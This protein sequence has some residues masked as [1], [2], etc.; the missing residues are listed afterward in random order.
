MN[1]PPHKLPVENISLQQLQALINQAT[2]MVADGNGPK[3]LETPQHTI[4]KLFR[5]KRR[6]SSALF[7]PYALR[8]VNNAFRIKEL[9]IPTVTPLSIR[10]CRASRIHV[11]EYE[12]LNGRLLRGELEQNRQPRLFMKTAQFIADLHYKG[13]YFRSLHFENIVVTDD[14]LGLIDV[15]DMKIYLKPLAASLRKRN[16]QHFLRYPQDKKLLS[17]YG[18]ERFNNEYDTHLSSLI[19]SDYPPP[20]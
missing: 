13:I 7:S 15:A 20:P 14:G 2:L 10:H 4:I 1:L 3:V 9:N 16:F 19:M 17:A 6:F 18:M 5:R 8:F 11:V 12:R